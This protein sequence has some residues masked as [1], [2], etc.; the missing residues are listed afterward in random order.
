MSKC[1]LLWCYKL[2]CHSLCCLLEKEEEN[3]LAFFPGRR[4]VDH[5]PD[6]GARQVNLWL[7]FPPSP[8]IP[9][10]DMSC[11]CF[12]WNALWDFGSIWGQENS[13]GVKAITELSHQIWASWSFLS[14]ILLG[15]TTE[16]MNF[17]VPGAAFWKHRDQK[18]SSPGVSCKRAF[19]SPLGRGLCG[20]GGWGG[21]LRIW[22]PFS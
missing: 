11:K 13:A 16:I 3:C 8:L 10:G 19:P 18:Y 14:I 5:K 12:L 6:W 17:E 2:S 20:K 4:E 7:R 1:P 22:P 21:G 15:S 9:R